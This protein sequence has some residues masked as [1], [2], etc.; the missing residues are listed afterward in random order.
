MLDE[1][2][3]RNVNPLIATDDARQASFA[4]LIGLLGEQVPTS[5]VQALG[6]L[7]RQWLQAAIADAGTTID[8][9]AGSGAYDLWVKMG[10]EELLVTIRPSRKGGA[11]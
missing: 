11:E 7:M 5:N 1:D 6:H 4:G 9:G 2:P 3:D 10:G 8:T